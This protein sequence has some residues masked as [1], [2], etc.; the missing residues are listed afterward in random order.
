[1]S[2][3]YDIADRYVLAYAALDPV[4]ATDAGV[5]GH[6]H[7]LTDYSPEASD[8]R[9]ELDRVTLAA[10]ERAKRADDRDR[11][12]ADV[13]TERL[14]LAVELHDA[15]EEL[16]ALRIIGSP[17]QDIRSCFDLMAYDTEADWE[18]AARRLA[19]VPDSLSSFE[20]ALREGINRGVVSA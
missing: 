2:E 15:G 5:A 10:L 1:M 9:D 3:V 7:Q 20:A 13:M 11:I 16:R 14:R 12:A 17:V 8:E 18:I 6:D 19:R 4:A